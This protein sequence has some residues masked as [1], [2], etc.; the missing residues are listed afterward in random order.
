MAC[1][2]RSVAGRRTRRRP[3]D[4]VGA[5]AWFRAKRVPG[6]FALADNVK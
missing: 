1:L 5:G 6:G 3:I 4:A 2:E